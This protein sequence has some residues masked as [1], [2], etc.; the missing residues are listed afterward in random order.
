MQASLYNYLVNCSLATLPPEKKL[1][2]NFVRDI[3]HSYEQQAQSPE[4]YYELLLHQHPYHLAAEHFNIP[5]E[6]ARK[7][8]LEMEQEVNEN[9]ERKAK[10][11]VWVDCT[12]KIEP[13]YYPKKL[14][15][16]SLT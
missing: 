8:M 4:Q 16:L 10:N 6:A 12:D 1:F 15:F 7:L 5:V 13:S 9:A 2:Y 14:F 3:E 11:V